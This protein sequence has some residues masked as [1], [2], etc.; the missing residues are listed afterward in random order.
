[1]TSGSL[2]LQEIIVSFQLLGGEVMLE[3][4]ERAK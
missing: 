1:M 4:S 3:L 2:R